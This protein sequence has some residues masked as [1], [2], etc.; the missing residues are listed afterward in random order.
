MKFR[1][2]VKRLSFRGRAGGGSESTAA[3]EGARIP[4]AL[5]TVRGIPH[6]P[7]EGRCGAP[8]FD[9]KLIAGKL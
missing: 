4:R 1:A 6:L 3:G 5:K 9:D 7:T 2:A 8:G